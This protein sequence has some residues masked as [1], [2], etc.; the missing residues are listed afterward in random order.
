MELNTGTD[1]LAKPRC[2]AC[3]RPLIY[4]V[5]MNWFY[6]LINRFH[7]VRKFFCVS[8]MSGKY[9]WRKHSSH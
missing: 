4:E 8:C 6:R 3:G 7:P 9:V 5:N 2:P 1:I